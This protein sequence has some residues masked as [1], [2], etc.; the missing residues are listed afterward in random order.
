[1]SGLT[2][3]TPLAR[4]ASLARHTGLERGA[5]PVRKTELRK[6]SAKRARTAPARRQLV[7][8]LLAGQPYCQAPTFAVD[9]LRPDLL[10]LFAD[11]CTRL[12]VDGHELLSRGRGGSHL[13]PANVVPL[14]RLCHDWVTRH[15][16]H[17]DALGLALSA[18]PRGAA[19]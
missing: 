10:A 15:P 14:C 12:A 6:V 8:A 2:R 7:A 11:R 18:V 17:A 5:G 16:T 19:A 9:A 3:T 13:D 1:M 4:G